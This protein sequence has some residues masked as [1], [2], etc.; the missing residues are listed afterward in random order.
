[1]KVPSIGKETVYKLLKIGIE[2]VKTL[3][4]I[5]VS[6]M[7]NLVGKNG[8]ELHR[9]AHGIDES[10]VVPYREQQSVGI[11]HTFEIDTIDTTFLYS[12]LVRM[13]EKIAYALRSKTNS[14]DALQ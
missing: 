5:A 2:T 13:T 4:E 3:S 6:L 12:Q 10:P 8:N 1:M 11:E 7:F 9:H 14:P